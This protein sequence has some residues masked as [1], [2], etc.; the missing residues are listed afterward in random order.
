MSSRNRVLV[1]DDEPIVR[2][3]FQRSL[4]VANFDV[5]VGGDGAEGLRIL[6]EDP[7]IGL[8]LLDLK[9]PGVDGWGFLKEQRADPQLATI[10][11]VILS[12]S[13]LGENI[14]EELQ[15]EGFLLKPVGR[16]HLISVVA[17]YCR[18]LHD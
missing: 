14:H 6:R 4:Q 8:V 9:M 13:T 10:P 11:T 5:V 7:T 1:V 16:D 2:M 15:V 18:P 12:G 17:V 3:V